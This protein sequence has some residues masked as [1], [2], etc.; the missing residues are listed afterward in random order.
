MTA[1]RCISADSHIMEPGDLWLRY[2]APKFRERAPRLIAGAEYDY[3]VC[4]GAELLPVAGVNQAGTASD[5]LHA[6]GRYETAVRK[7]AWDPDARIA[8]MQRD[9]VDAEVLYPT[10]A[11]R[12]F[13][14]ED[15]AYQ[16]AC[17]RAYNDWISDFCDTYP[18]RLKAIA[19]LP[20]CNVTDAVE[21]MKRV[22]KRG[23]AG[24]AMSISGDD[25]Q[26]YASN[27]CD[28]LWAA[29]QDLDLPVSLHSLTERK[30]SGKRDISDTVLEC[31][32]MQRALSHMVFAGVFER[33][34]R[35][36]LVS[37]ENDAG[38]MGY[39]LERLDYVFD[40]RRNY[41]AMHLSRK[42]PP[43]EL[44]RRAT[45]LTF[46]RDRSAIELRDS[47]GVDRLMWASDYPHQ[48]ST[49]PESQQMIDR[50]AD[51]V[52]P[53]QR[54]MIVAENAARLYGFD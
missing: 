35:L 38:W 24:V 23:A 27:A 21:E 17:F 18:K 52:P 46:M 32:W 30:R 50:L 51:G 2:I 16:V 40:R 49:W 43:S 4:E 19:L 33:F 44:V 54:Q 34:P 11:L 3:Y 31:I 6:Y 47:I 45:W 28:P 36:K 15:Q 12:M 29:A 1:F 26:G 53:P 39:L 5:E 25:E 37:A 8:D 9:G 22:R 7:G 41:F 14:I 48:D 13:S 10:M 20:N 42:T